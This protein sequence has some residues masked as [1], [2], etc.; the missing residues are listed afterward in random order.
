MTKIFVAGATGYIGTNVV[1][2]A[3]E[4]NFDVVA[5]TR[6]DDTNF[7]S[8]D[9]NLSVIKISDSDNSWM[10]KL[11]DIDV[12][13]SCLA[14]RSGEP[15][16]AHHVDY[17][18]NKL[19]LE[20]A[21][22]INC[23]QFI[24]L[25]AICVQKPKLAFQFEKLAFEETLRNSG[26]NFSIIRPTAYFKSLSGQIENI[27]RGK[28]YVYFGDGK[29]T[30]CNPISEKDLSLYILSCI[31][32]ENKWR[33]ILPIGGPNQSLTPKK[34]GEMLFEIFEITPRYRS[35]PTRILDTIGLFFYVV[36]P[37]SNWA[38]KKSELIKIAKYY[39]TESMLVWDEAKL[40]YD[41]LKT[42]STGNDTLEQYF[43]AI[44]KQKMRLNIDRDSKLY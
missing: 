3:L 1:K 9:K 34:I 12:F 2:S 14:S 5:A 13:I 43:H 39:A 30:Q 32:D 40:C 26:L 6:K 28:P 16:D 19:L 11:Q 33:K 25:S 44:K 31:K 23:P 7:I 15:K 17:K 4:Q 10:S 8:K 36:S 35:F 37:F 20:K 27:K 22:A 42:P 24:L 18:L 38:K 41:A 21:M 29:L